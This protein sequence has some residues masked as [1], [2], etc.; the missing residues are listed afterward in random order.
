MMILLTV[1]VVVS[2]FVIVVGNVDVFVVQFV[3]RLPGHFIFF[4]KPP[5]RVGKPGTN[6]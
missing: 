6:L 1:F 5:S 2:I 3:F 4:F